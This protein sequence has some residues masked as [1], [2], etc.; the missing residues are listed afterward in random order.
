MEFYLKFFQ[1]FLFFL[2]SQYIL[3]IIELTRIHLFNI[4]TQ[5]RAIFSDEDTVI[6]SINVSSINEINIFYSWLNEKVGL[7]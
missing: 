2:G 5:Y 3:K 4:I 6:P 7:N 1:I